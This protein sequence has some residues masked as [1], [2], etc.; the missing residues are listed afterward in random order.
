MAGRSRIAFWGI[1]AFFAG[2]LLGCSRPAEDGRDLESLAPRRTL[3]AR[4]PGLPFGYC[5]LVG[6]GIGLRAACPR[7]NDEESGELTRAGRKLRGAAPESGGAGSRVERLS[8]LLTARTPVEFSFSL[9]RLERHARQAEAA[10]GPP[11]AEALTDLAAAYL[12]R[13]EVLGDANDY[14]SAAEA[15]RAAL[16]EVPDDKAA[17]FDLALAY[18]RLLLRQ[19][20]A[21]T[22]SRLVRVETSGGWAAEAAAHLSRLTGA[23]QSG[24][25]G[26]P[27]DLEAE[28]ERA[29]DVLLPSWAAAAD[30]APRSPAAAC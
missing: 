8:S 18:E 10:G 13:A 6:G 27:R 25:G 7:P 14:L 19:A 28:R 30:A 22:W 17:L 16:A 20:A 2:I 3:E 23:A 29:L 12:Q 9:R 24:A 1:P 4:L 26:E 5:P 21:R 15:A 11:A